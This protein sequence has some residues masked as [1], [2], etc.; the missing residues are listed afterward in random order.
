MGVV[1]DT[2]NQFAVEQGGQGSPMRPGIIIISTCIVGV[3][4]SSSLGQFL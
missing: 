1:D 2:A 3:F 4:V